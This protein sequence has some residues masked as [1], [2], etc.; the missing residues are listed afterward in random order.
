MASEVVRGGS[1]HA[2]GNV[3]HLNNPA[4]PFERVLRDEGKEGRVNVTDL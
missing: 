4:F 2:H 3:I 1:V